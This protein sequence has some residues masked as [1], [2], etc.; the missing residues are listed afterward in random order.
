MDKP[1][2]PKL[3]AVEPIEPA[4]DRHPWR[5]W[6]EPECWTKPRVRRAQCDIDDVS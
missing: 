6:Q 1:E 4:V 3:H 2:Q 5:P